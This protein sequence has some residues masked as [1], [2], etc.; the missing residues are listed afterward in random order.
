[1]NFDFPEVLQP[2]LA[3]FNL[4]HIQ[5]LE[6]SLVAKLGEPLLLDDNLGYL[7]FRHCEGAFVIA[8]S[9]SNVGI[10]IESKK[11]IVRNVEI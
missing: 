9:S 3:L 11:R 6:V 5:P 10:D 7:S 2:R 1:M 8:R 4:F